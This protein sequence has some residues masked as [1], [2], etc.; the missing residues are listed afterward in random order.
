PDLDIGGKLRNK[1]NLPHSYLRKITQLIGILLLLY[2]L[3]NKADT[4]PYIG[5]GIGAGIFLFASIFKQRH[6][7]MITGVFVAVGGYFLGEHWILLF[8]VYILIASISSHR[9]YTHSLVGLCFF[10]LISYL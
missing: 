10:G 7:L 2:S 8:G 3:F 9:S 6:M 5:V 1:L 4:Y